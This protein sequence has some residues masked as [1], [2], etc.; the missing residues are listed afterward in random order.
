[1]RQIVS[2]FVC[3]KLFRIAHQT[4]QS[5]DILFYLM[6]WQIH[7]RTKRFTHNLGRTY[8]L[9]I[10]INYQLYI[11]FFIISRT[12]FVIPSRGFRIYKWLKID[13][14]VINK[15]RIKTA[16]LVLILCTGKKKEI[17]KFPE[18][19]IYILTFHFSI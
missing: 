9:F 1:M 7:W 2:H 12:V 19:F 11:L 10:S 6:I 18:N 3:S 8:L 5:H 4:F 15:I 16:N 17:T 14:I 13:D